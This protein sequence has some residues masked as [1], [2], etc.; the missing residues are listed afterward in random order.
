MCLNKIEN[1]IKAEI[2]LICVYNLVLYISTTTHQNVYYFYFYS[3]YNFNSMYTIQAL[4]MVFHSFHESH[5]VKINKI[6]SHCW[7]WRDI[8]VLEETKNHDG[9]KSNK[10][11]YRVQL[12]LFFLHH[13]VVLNCET[14]RYVEADHSPSELVCLRAC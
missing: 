10:K 13:F 4:I 12:C 14:H 6:S 1:K 11:N 8:D 9:S 2:H 7:I 3:T 5:R